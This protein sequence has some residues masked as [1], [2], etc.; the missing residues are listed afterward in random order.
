MVPNEVQIFKR[1]GVDAQVPQAAWEYAD[2][3]DNGRIIYDLEDGWACA[4]YDKKRDM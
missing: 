4:A 2:D 1:N 3:L